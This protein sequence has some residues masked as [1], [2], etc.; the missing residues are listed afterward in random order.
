[1]AGD[2]VGPVGRAWQRDGRCSRSVARYAEKMIPV[3]MPK[4][5]IGTRRGYVAAGS[6]VVSDLG[7]CL[8]VCFAVAT[9]I[10]FAPTETAPRR[11]ETPISK[12]TSSD[13]TYW[14]GVPYH[15][16][17]DL[18]DWQEPSQLMS[19]TGGHAPVLVCAEVYNALL[20]DVMRSLILSGIF[21]LEE[22]SAE[23]K[24]V[25]IP[26]VLQPL[27]VFRHLLSPIFDQCSGSQS[28]DRVLSGRSSPVAR[29]KIGSG[30]IDDLE[31]LRPGEHDRR[32]ALVRHLRI[33][34]A[35]DCYSSISRGPSGPRDWLDGSLG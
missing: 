3:E 28:L 25:L 4:S 16:G 15:T 8:A 32:R 19:E 9:W 12:P 13:E 24:R 20:I 21:R 6:P 14:R 33:S 11:D 31:R 2:K 5:G 1:M 10:R 30:P 29:S 22:E 35:R 34:P 18:T 7:S 17:T 23:R 27:E 26:T